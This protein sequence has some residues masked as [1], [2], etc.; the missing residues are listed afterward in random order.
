M[1]SIF[2]L[3]Y[4]EVV[5]D[6][7]IR[8][9][10]RTGGSSYVIT[11]PKEW[12][13][14]SQV[15]K[16]DPL[17]VV[18][19]PDGNLLITREI[20]EDAVIRE[21]TIDVSRICD[22]DYLF[23]LLVS[24]YISGYTIINILSKDRLLPFV[25]LKVRDFTA[26]AIG[27]HVVE[28]TDHSILL[29]DLLNPVEM[30]FENTI[31]RMYVLVRTM[32][33]DALFALEK[34]DRALLDEVIMRDNDVDRLHWLIA[35]Q[36]SMILL[37]GALGRKMGVST[38]FVLHVFT[39]S[40]II[41]RIGDHAVRIAE[42]VRKIVDYGP[43]PPVVPSMRQISELSVRI[44]DKSI[45]SF[46][47]SDI[48]ESNRNIGMVEEL[49]R[50]SEEVAGR[51]LENEIQVAVALRNIAES[52]RRSGEYAGDISETVMNYLVMANRD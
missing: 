37:N 42:Q 30:P 44:F 24:A 16:N 39:I 46:F 23:R 52:I 34:K 45:T 20:R 19:Q 11:L 40:R 33:E 13:E 7:E 6:M 3:R 38:P 2:I 10:Q 14:A 36:T 1:Y 43:V 29:K 15:K 49:E 32:H 26:M 9:V 17:G 51:V 18:V 47:A 12:I 31:K 48:L 27:P 35:R 22:P 4:G 41:E 5:T 25:R 21:K 50:L 8:K 28:E